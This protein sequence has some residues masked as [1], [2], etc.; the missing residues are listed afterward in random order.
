MKKQNILRASG[1][2]VIFAV[3]GLLSACNSFTPFDPEGV[4][5]S[6]DKDTISAKLDTPG[7]VKVSVFK[8]SKTQ[9][10][11]IV[12]WDVWDPEPADCNITVKVRPEDGDDIPTDTYPVMRKT[13]LIFT[14]SAEQV[15]T[16][17]L[18]IKVYYDDEDYV[19]DYCSIPII[20]SNSGD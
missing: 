11:Y 8:S 17:T 6:P 12:K 15:G 16:A 5:L 1:V 7:K 20:V 13:N 10:A 9:D 14:V 4:S 2:L 3:L 19:L 18:F